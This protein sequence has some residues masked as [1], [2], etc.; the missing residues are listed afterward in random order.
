MELEEALDWKQREVA[1]AV[2]LLFVL[3]GKSFHLV[4]RIRGME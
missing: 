2:P 4:S 1:L 3:T